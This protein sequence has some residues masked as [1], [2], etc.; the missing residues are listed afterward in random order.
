MFVK[1]KSLGLRLICFILKTF[2][3]VVKVKPVSHIK[4]PLIQRAGFLLLRLCYHLDKAHT[5]LNNNEPAHLA[6]YKGNYEWS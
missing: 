4:F 6:P 1:F 5:H 2:D 3:F